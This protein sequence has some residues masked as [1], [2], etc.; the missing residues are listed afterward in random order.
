MEGPSARRDQRARPTALPNNRPNRRRAEVAAPAH[1]H[2][3]RLGSGIE[4]GE[5]ARASSCTNSQGVVPMTEQ[6]RRELALTDDDRE[7]LLSNGVDLPGIELNPVAGARGY[8]I[9]AW[10][11]GEIELEFM[12]TPD[13][14]VGS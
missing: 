4:G 11:N 2:K 10:I 9:S 5:L 7:T 13:A 6:R 1:S 3:A 12:V 8:H 14:P